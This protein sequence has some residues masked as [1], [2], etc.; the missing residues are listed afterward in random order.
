MVLDDD[1]LGTGHPDESIEHDT[2]HPDPPPPG[3]RDSAPLPS[4]GERNGGGPDDDDLDVDTVELA[5]DVQGL[6]GNFP[7]RLT[8]CIDE[9]KRM[10]ASPTIIDWIQHGYPVQW[11]SEARP[12]CKNVRNNISGKTF[13]DDDTLSTFV[14]DAIDEMR[15]AG[16]CTEVS[17]A[18]AANLSPLSVAPKSKAGPDGKPRFRLIMNL[19][20]T[21]LFIKRPPHLKMETLGRFRYRIKPGC[22]CAGIDLS[23]GYFHQRLR[24]EDQPY[25]SFAHEGRYYSMTS[26]P[27]GGRFSPFCFTQLT[28]VPVAHWRRESSLELIHYLDDFFFTSDS[29]QKTNEIFQKCVADLRRLGFKVNTDKC[30]PVH[31]GPVRQGEAPLGVASQQCEC[32]GFIVNSVTHTFDVDPDRKRRIITFLSHAVD[33]DGTAAVADLCKAT[34]YVVSL[35][36]S[37]GNQALLMCR[38]LY[39]DIEQRIHRLGCDGNCSR[40]CYGGRVQVSDASQKDLACLANDLVPNAHGMPIWRGMTTARAVHLCTDASEHSM[41]AGLVGQYRVA[42]APFDD[43]I[44]GASSLRRELA[45]VRFGLVTLTQE[46]PAGTTVLLRVDNLGA[47]QL[48]SRGDGSATAADDGIIRDIL[49]HCASRRIFLVVNWTP[50]ELNEWAD[51]ISKLVDHGDWMIQ[52]MLFKALFERFRGFNY[53]LFSSGRTRQSAPDGRTVAWFSRWAEPGSSG[54]AFAADWGTLGRVWACPPLALIEFCIVKAHLE[55]AD[56]VIVLPKFTNMLWRRWLFGS[57]GHRH[58]AIVGVVDIGKPARCF[59]PANVAGRDG[60]LVP[61]G[62]FQAVHIDFTTTDEPLLDAVAKAPDTRAPR[63]RR[64]HR[65]RPVH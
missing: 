16:A 55:R 12:S 10:G 8:E 25:F 63:A 36:L 51:H 65:R 13:A 27:F 38:N 48:L 23:C 29:R 46:L 47:Y 57:N 30:S 26:M 40:R 6:D 59:V 3:A 34:G 18:E 7:Y 62:F 50:R 5:A 31:H 56:I 22:W 4:S 58:N 42:C 49:S 1:Y 11:L 9:W 43:D 33:E 20:D 60:R 14:N 41:G 44:V 61:S 35:S 39:R 24:S 28:R 52:P 21:N 19:I 54:D 45:A 17:K 15:A 37:L 2:K 64:K 53:D 32:L